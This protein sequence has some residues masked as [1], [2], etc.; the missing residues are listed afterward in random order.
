VT[1]SAAA[2]GAVGAFVA[3]VAVVAFFQSREPSVAAHAVVAPPPS[4]PPPTLVARPTPTPAFAATATA[5]PDARASL[6]T[7][8]LTVASFPPARVFDG[9]RLLCSATPCFN[10]VLAAGLH[11]LVFVSA[12]DTV[13]KLVRIEVVASQTRELRIAMSP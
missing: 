9:G 12:D 7:G 11:D 5:T 3:T 13:K 10:T 1:L 6:P 2:G 8:A 4:P